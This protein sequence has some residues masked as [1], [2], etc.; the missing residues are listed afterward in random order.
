ME[1]H[2][3]TQGAIDGGFETP[4]VD[5]DEHREHPVPHRYVHGGF[6]GTETLFSF[7]F[8]AVDQYEG[9][10]FQHVTP[11]PDSE[12]LAQ[13]SSGREGKIDF[14]IASGAYFVET[15][16]GGPGFAMPGG[17]GDPTISAYRAN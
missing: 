11:I 9:R 17:D 12:K 4:F 10:F 8:P 14:A 2:I 1:Q 16:G 15:N 13:S 5:A 7:Y 3:I 6:E